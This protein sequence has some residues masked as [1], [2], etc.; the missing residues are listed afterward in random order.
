V[1][2]ANVELAIAAFKAFQERDIDAIKAICSPDVEF[3]WSRRLLDPVVIRGYQGIQAFFD[4]VDAIF[5]EMTFSIDEVLEF[6]DDVVMVST[7][8]FRGRSS[9][10]DVTARAANVWTIKDGKLARFCF[11]QSKED[12]LADLQAAD[13][14]PSAARSTR[15]P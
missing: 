15:A 8:H 14:Q 2:S 9:G 5:D 1:A 6:G 10:V 11:Y 13:A 3:D 7:G 12:A 4:E